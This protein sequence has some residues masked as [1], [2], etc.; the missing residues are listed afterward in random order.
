MKLLADENIP[1]LV[2]NQLRRAG[3]DVVWAGTDCKGANDE[4]VVERA[5]DEERVLLTFD[6]DFGE[7][8]F[9]QGLSSKSGVVLLRLKLHAPDYVLQH[10][11][12]H[13]EHC[14]NWLGHFVV[15]SEFKIRIRPLPG[16]AK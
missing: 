7:L 8:A 16:S 4:E 15:I 5:R 6:K 3:H 11:L 10:V 13:F 9:H 14:E 2:I 1:Y 12:G